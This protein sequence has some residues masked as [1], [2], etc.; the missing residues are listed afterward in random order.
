MRQS[1]QRRD[2]TLDEDAVQIVLVRL[3]QTIERQLVLEIEL[4][5]VRCGV[6]KCDVVI[7]DP[8]IGFEVVMKRTARRLP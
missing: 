7:C 2:R 4:G 8:H 3:L 6:R 5:E 1:T